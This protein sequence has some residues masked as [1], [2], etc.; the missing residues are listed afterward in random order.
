MSFHKHEFFFNDEMSKN[1]EFF[2]LDSISSE[3]NELIKSRINDFKTKSEFFNYYSNT[4]II[5]LFESF[6]KLDTMISK[7]NNH[8]NDFKSKVDKYISELSNIFL[9]F[10]LISKNQQIVM[11]VITE[12]QSHLSHFYVEYNISKDSQKKFDEYFCKLMNLQSVTN[13]KNFSPL[14]V[15][16]NNHNILIVNQKTEENNINFN[17]NLINIFPPSNNLINNTSEE[18]K[19]LDHLLTPKFPYKKEREEDTI[20]EINVNKNIVLKQESLQSSFTLA[21]KNQSSQNNQEEI[22]NNTKDTTANK[23][24][25]SQDLHMSNLLNSSEIELIYSKSK[26]SDIKK[27]GENEEHEMKIGFTQ[28]NPTKQTFSCMNLKSKLE[29]SMLKDTLGIINNLYKNGEI[30]KEEKIQLKKL[31]ITKSEKL[32]RL[33]KFYKTSDSVFINELKNLII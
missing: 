20:K 24:K 4:N 10:S 14:N 2:L 16:T 23:E 5:S 1:I 19:S 33:N 12:S 28:K 26:K 17:C 32:T 27:E 7:I 21:S 6:D 15:N 31:I 3:K 25:S 18:E 8:N 9:L 11:K 29:R 13:N 22:I 30:T